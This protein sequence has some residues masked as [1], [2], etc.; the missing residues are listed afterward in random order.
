[1]EDTMTTMT[2]T[3]RYGKGYSGKLGNKCWIAEITGSDD[4]YGLQRT[5]LEPSKV[6][7]QHFNRPRTIIEVSYELV[8]D[9][10]YE[11]SA[12]G[13]RWFAMCYETNKGEIKTAKLSDA[14]VKA[15]V[16]AL[17]EGKTNREA[18]L[19]TKGL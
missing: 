14:R 4:T 5:F 7:R 11:L 18:R 19:A 2:R 15:W 13:D 3:L 6:E 8:V 9:G 17:D 12:E 1:M 16:A 10:L